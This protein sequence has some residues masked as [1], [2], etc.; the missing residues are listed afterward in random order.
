M[1]LFKIKKSDVPTRRK[2][3]DR[4]PRPVDNSSEIFKRNRTLTGTTSI[5]FDAA[6]IKSDLESPRTQVHHLVNKRRRV[7]SVF[8]AVLLITISIWLLVSNFTAAVRISVSDTLVSKTI[9]SSVYEQAI[10]EYLGVNPIGRF[11][12]LLDKSALSDYVSNKLPEVESVA[13]QDMIGVGTTTFTVN[14]RRPVAG[15]KIDDKQ[16]YVDSKGI[17][18]ETNYYEAPG[19]Q[20]VDS[21]GISVQKGIAVA[22][23]KFLSFV[24][25]VVTLAKSNGYTVT[26]AVIPVNTIRILE[27]NL[28]ECSYPIKLS[29]DRPAGEQVE[30]MARAVKYLIDNGITPSYVDVR[31]G[32][33]AFYK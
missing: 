21:S 11:R 17:P 18:F 20:I 26:K 19:V 8:S 10:Q 29:I 1:S 25:R 28:R 16:Y 33:K 5:R 4:E 24:G 2:V 27:V 12:F 15:W 22:S 23:K 32:G 14:M 31:V 6:N 3:S 30:D 13:M 9:K 7:F